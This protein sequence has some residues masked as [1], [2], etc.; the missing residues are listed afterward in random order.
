MKLMNDYKKIITD[1]GYI[2]RY[3]TSIYVNSFKQTGD[4]I[5]I[6]GKIDL[7]KC[8]I[9]NGSK[10][11]YFNL[12]FKKIIE[13]TAISEEHVYSK[14]HLDTESSFSEI[15]LEDEQYKKIILES[16]DWTYIIKCKE[17]NIDFYEYER[18]SKCIYLIGKE[19]FDYIKELEFKG[20]SGKYDVEYSGNR[21]ILYKKRYGLEIV[22]VKVTDNFKDQ[23]DIVPYD[24]TH[25]TEIRYLSEDIIKKFIS[26]QIFPKDLY[27]YNNDGLTVTIDE[28][29]RKGMPLK[30]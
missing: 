13:Y 25:I 15:R 27:I 20:S 24:N 11:V 28:F 5:I 6:N 9:Q 1:I 14:Y 19:G 23:M 30:N 8:D 21:V 2:K 7:D 12:Y 22:N 18:T 10:W 17:Y 4:Q 26:N 29:I 16:Y 3:R